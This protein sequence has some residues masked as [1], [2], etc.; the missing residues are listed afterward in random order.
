MQEANDMYRAGYS[1]REIISAL[2][3][4]VSERQLQRKFKSSGVI[5]GIKNTYKCT[6]CKEIKSRDQFTKNK[7]RGNGIESYC[8]TCAPL[9]S[10]QAV[11]NWVN[12]NRERR[13][14]QDLAGK[15]RHEIKKAYCEKCGVT[16]KLE[17]HHY[18]YSKPLDVIT[19]CKKH[20][21]EIHHVR[22]GG[23]EKI[24]TSRNIR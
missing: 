24:Y 17:M 6:F 13:R 2:H 9:H 7:A 3:L 18:D 22:H 15:H 12:N 19:V 20:H 10:K 1:A 5:K 8:K 16:E 14:A 21:E 4:S 23:Y 11:K